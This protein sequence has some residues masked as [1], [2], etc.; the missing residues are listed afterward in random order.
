MPA[1]T[2]SHTHIHTHTHTHTRT[3]VIMV[4]QYN[5]EGLRHQSAV[6][7]RGA[8]VQPVTTTA[9]ASASPP[10]PA[11]PQAARVGINAP[12]YYGSAPHFGSHCCCCCCCR[13][14][15]RQESYS[16]DPAWRHSARR[17]SGTRG[18]PPLQNTG[19]YVLYSGNL[20]E[21][22]TTS[23]QL[24]LTAGFYWILSAATRKRFA[25]FLLPG[26]Q[27]KLH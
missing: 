27:I 17:L 7:C 10:S 3:Q 5:A 13:K 2:H 16:N 15:R 4:H 22:E 19:A 11:V 25:F 21:W 24:M 14:A 12:R 9:P 20:H 26:Y 6:Q 23:E 1:C 8:A 18:Q